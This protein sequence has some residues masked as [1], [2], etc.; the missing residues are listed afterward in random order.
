[1]VDRDGLM[2]RV[3]EERWLTGSVATRRQGKI[4]LMEIADDHDGQDDE[5]ATQDVA[6]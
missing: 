4:R 1:M 6:T 5:D 3:L 2:T